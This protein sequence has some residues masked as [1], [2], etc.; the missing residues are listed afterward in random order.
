M[1]T[2][3]SS[4]SVPTTSSMVE[5]Y[6]NVIDGAFRGFLKLHPDSSYASNVTARIVAWQ[7][8]RDLVAAGNIKLHG[9]WSPVAEAARQI[10]RGRGQQLLQQARLLI[11]QGRFESAIQ[12]LQLVVHMDGQPELVSQA[13]PLLDSAYQK[14]V[15]LVDQRRQKLEGDV[16]SARQRVEQARQALS[17]AEA[18][19][20]ASGVNSQSMVQAQTAVDNARNDLSS[21]QNHLGQI[22]SQ[23]DSV[24]LRLVTLKSQA[25]ATTVEVPKAQPAPAPAASTDTLTDIVTWAKKNWAGMAVIALALLFLLSR[26]F[27]D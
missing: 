3:N 22:K 25:S 23:L 1:K 10:G 12:P 26:F 8:E 21:A 4:N 13:K 11:S 19:Q 16:S 2:C 17:E 15:S 24:A 6:D 20:L 9:R 14:A 27:K 5:Y 18:L 7:A